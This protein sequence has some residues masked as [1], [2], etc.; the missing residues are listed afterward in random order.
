MGMMTP[1]EFEILAR[2]LRPQLVRTARNVLH[3]DSAAQDVAQDTLLK[4]WTMRD[5]LDRYRS[6][7]ALASVMAHRMALNVLRAASPGRFVELDE[8]TGGVPSAE[9]ELLARENGRHLDAVLASLPVPQ[10][11][12]IRLRHIEGYDNAAIAA[13]LGSSEGAVRTALSRARRRI[14]AAFGVDPS[15]YRNKN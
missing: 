13:L 2:S 10:Q 15:L 3:D 12:L 11:T 5:S 7:D 1:R 6:V 14:A 4:L 9:D 8:N